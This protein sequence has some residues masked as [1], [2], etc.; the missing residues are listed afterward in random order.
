MMEISK[1]FRFEAAHS[2]PGLPNGHPCKKLHGHSYQLVVYVSGKPNEYGMVNDYGEISTLVNRL[3]VKYLD[4][5]NLNEIGIAQPTAE[6]LCLYVWSYL[7]TEINGLS[8]VEIKET[9]S[10][11]CVYRP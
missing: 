6:N 1:R 7:A 5:S 8:A 9:E 11:S 4:H 2:L 3:V 10:T